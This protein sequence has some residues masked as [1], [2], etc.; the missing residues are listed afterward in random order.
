MGDRFGKLQVVLAEPP[1]LAAVDSQRAEGLLVLVQRHGQRAANSQ[2]AEKAVVEASLGSQVFA[3]HGNGRAQGV[4]RHRVLAPQRR[5]VDHRP[6]RLRVQFAGKNPQR[7][8]VPAD[9]VRGAAEFRAHDFRHQGDGVL[10]ED[11]QAG[12]GV[13]ATA[14]GEH[15]GLPARVRIANDLVRGRFRPLGVQECCVQC[16]HATTEIICYFFV[17]HAN[18]LLALPIIALLPPSTPRGGEMYNNLGIKWPCIPSRRGVRAACLIA[19]AP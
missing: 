10:R 13:G 12:A 15:R 11:V 16:G 9:H 1:R 17:W 6:N 8:R 14:E 2:V 18:R 5:F 7:Q 19:S 4:T 3:G